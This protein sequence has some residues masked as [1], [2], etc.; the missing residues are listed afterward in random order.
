MIT[1]YLENGCVATIRTSG[2]E[3]KIKW[4]IEIG[5]S[6]MEKATKDLD[7]VVKAIQDDLLQRE[8]YGLKHSD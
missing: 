4:Y 8:K 1:F 7:E 5:A 6:N 2:T 3:P